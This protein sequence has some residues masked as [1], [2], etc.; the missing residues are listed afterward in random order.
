MKKQKERFNATFSRYEVNTPQPQ[1]VVSTFQLCRRRHRD[2]L[3]TLRRCCVSIGQFYIRSYEDNATVPFISNTFGY[4]DFWT[5]SVFFCTSLRERFIYCYFS[6]FIPHHF[7]G[8]K[9]ISSGVIKILSLWV[10]CSSALVGNHL[11]MVSRE[12]TGPYPQNGLASGKHLVI[13][14]CHF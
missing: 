7:H 4:Q 10:N 2:I 1:I 13:K 11:K 14:F 5:N 6:N 8:M 3:L 9:L 12:N